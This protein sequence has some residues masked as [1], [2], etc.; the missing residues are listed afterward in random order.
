MINQKNGKDKMSRPSRSNRAGLTE[1]ALRA[2]ICEELRRVIA[3]RRVY[4]SA[5]YEEMHSAIETILDNLR[6]LEPPH[7]VPARDAREAVRDV[8]KAL[9][10]LSELID[11]YGT[12]DR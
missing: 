3:E 5:E 12:E 7:I 2:I 8:Q 1:S 11:R 4:R 10:A 6:F 9:Q